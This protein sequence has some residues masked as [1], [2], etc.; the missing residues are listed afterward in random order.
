VTKW[1]DSSKGLGGS[2]NPNQGWSLFARGDNWGAD[3]NDFA[4]SWNGTNENWRES[5]RIKS[6]TGNVG[7]GTANP[8]Q[9]L[10][11]NGKVN[12][13]GG[14]IQRGGT[15][16]TA[17]YDLGLY[18]RNAGNWMRFVTNDAPITFFTSEGAD[19]TGTSERMRITNGGNVG[20]GTTDPSNAKLVVNGQGSTAGVQGTSSYGLGILADTQHTGTGVYGQGGH[21][22]IGFTTSPQRTGAPESWGEAVIG[23]ADV[24][25]NFRDNWSQANSTSTWGA[26][27]RTMNNDFAGIFGYGI[28][29][30][31]AGGVCKKKATVPTCSSLS[32]SKADCELVGCTYHP[33]TGCYK[34]F[35]TT[36]CSGCDCSSYSCN[37]TCPAGHGSDC[38]MNCCTCVPTAYCDG[39]PNPNCG[40]YTTS[41]DCTSGIRNNF[42]YWE[43]TISGYSYAGWFE[44]DVKVTGNIN[45]TGKLNFNKLD[46]KSVENTGTHHAGT[47]L[48]DVSL[49][50]GSFPI[51]AECKYWDN[52]NCTSSFIATATLWGQS[53]TMAGDTNR[54]ECYLENSN[55]N[56]D[57]GN[58]YCYG[59]RPNADCAKIKVWYTNKPW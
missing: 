11:V 24:G 30:L 35:N 54:C 51:H 52:V 26:L 12:I 46:T 45:V 48:A 10:D 7:I 28:G 16:I 9:Q 34:Q 57:S 47:G 6:T 33:S 22:I 37:S 3:K 50:S 32:G 25:G 19:G 14:V 13:S 15:A 29:N 56:W 44:G 23:I 8:I 39:T 59:A 17:T 58:W 55:A 38:V 53:Y 5:L 2:T 21:G 42:C 31:T 36:E 40:A 1:P 20:I 27:G 18:S 43:T 41:G 4:I 49:P